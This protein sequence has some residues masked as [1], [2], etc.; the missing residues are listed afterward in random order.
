M[1]NLREQRVKLV[2]DQRVILDHANTEGRGLSVD[3]MATFDKID[4]EIVNLKATIDRSEANEAAGHVDELRITS[5]EP[6][7]TAAPETTAAPAAPSRAAGR[8]A[9]EY[10][11]AF[12]GYLRGGAFERRALEAGTN[13]E[14]GY[15]VPEM[16]AASMVV[17]KA[18]VNVMRQLSNVVTTTT[19]TLNLAAVASFSG[20]ASWTAEEA[21]ISE[22]DDAFSTVQFTA[23]K[24]ATLVKVSDELLADNAF[25]LEGY[26]SSEFGRRIGKL[27]EAAFVDGDASSKPKG[28]IYNSGVGVT[29][30][31]ATAVTAAELIELYHAL[32]SE[33]RASASWIMHDDTALL[34]RKL[35]DGNSQYLWQPGLQAG[36]PDV[37]LGRPVYTTS[38]CPQPTTA[39][40]AI[41][42]G[43]MSYYWIVDRAGMSVQRLNELYAAN[44]QVGFLA[45]SRTDGELTVAAASKVLQMA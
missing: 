12:D 3:E 31:S 27:E 21:S 8:S 19:G 14:G 45:S 7:N 42:F 30:A 37:L 35:V 44:G 40:K 22:S 1:E 29:A 24:A 28:V 11:A 33:Y 9:D 38:G 23:Y 17:A 10:R 36:Q 2:A 6:V 13:S 32:G 43:D 25:D 4:A 15:L 18:S 41:V 26:L 20:S 34:I 16:W 5:A 39:K